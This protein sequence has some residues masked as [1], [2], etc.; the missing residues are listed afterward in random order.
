MQ[1]IRVFVQIF[2]QNTCACLSYTPYVTYVRGRDVVL[3]PHTGCVFSLFAAADVFLAAVQIS[4]YVATGG[5][6]AQLPPSLFP[7]L[8]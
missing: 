5:A 1:C 4:T 2:G 7:I 8:S 6:A 3:M